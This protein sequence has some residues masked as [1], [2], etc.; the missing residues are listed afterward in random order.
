MPPDF[1]RH[2]ASGSKKWK[3]SIRVASS[4][5]SIGEWMVARDIPLVNLRTGAGAG[6]GQGPRGVCTRGGSNKPD[7]VGMH[8]QPR[9]AEPWGATWARPADPHLH[10]HSAAR[11]RVP[12]PHAAVHPSAH[13]RPLRVPLFGTSPQAAL[14]RL[15]QLLTPSLAL[16]SRAAH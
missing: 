12:V 2:A 7:Y 6:A 14:R 5:K 16:S 4:G 13:K 1:E 3:E 9:S 11:M 15:G 10:F 8:M